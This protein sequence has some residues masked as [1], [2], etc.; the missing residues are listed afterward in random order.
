MTNQRPSFPDNANN[1]GVL[2]RSLS[3]F[4][5]II[6]VL[7]TLFLTLSIIMRRGIAVALALVFSVLLIIFIIY[8][9]G[10]GSTTNPE[11]ISER[12]R[13]ADAYNFLYD[14]IMPSIL[15]DFADRGFD[16]DAGFGASNTGTI[17]FNEPDRAAAAIQTFIENVVPRDYMQDRAE[18]FMEQIASYA[19]GRQ[20]EFSIDLQLDDRVR[21]LP[22]AVRSASAEISL[23]EI[24][25]NDIMAPI[26][27]STASELTFP[28]LGISFTPDEVLDAANRV[29]PADWIDQ[30]VF[31]AVDQLGPYLSGDADSFLINID[32]SERIPV[33]GDVLVETVQQKELASVLLFERVIDPAV[34]QAV[35]ELTLL[36]Y[37][38]PITGDEITE[39][40][41]QFAPTAWIE[42]E[43]E[44]VVVAV[45][46]YI[47]GESDSLAYSIDLKERKENGLDHLTELADAKLASVLSD[48]PKCKNDQQLVLAA[49]DVTELRLPRCSESGIDLRELRSAAV[50]LF[51]NEIRDRLLIHV[52]DTVG[53]TD[54]QFRTVLGLDATN[55]LEAVRNTIQQG[56][57]YTD[58]D[59]IS[60]WSKTGDPASFRRA[61]DTIR[62]G[63]IYS[64]VEF[65]RDYQ[66]FLDSQNI[67]ATIKGPSILFFNFD[68]STDL[69]TSRANFGRILGSIFLL[70]S[71]LLLLLLF[72]GLLGGRN[73][74]SR[75]MWVAGAVV[76]SASI[77]AVIF[78]PVYLNVGNTVS[79][80]IQAGIS[81]YLDEPLSS[82]PLT[83]QYTSFRSDFP[84]TAALVD[85]GEFVVRIKVFF[86]GMASGMLSHSLM[87][88]MSGLIVLS[89]ALVL[90]IYSRPGIEP[91]ETWTT[92]TGSIKERIGD[93]RRDQT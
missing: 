38:V 59:L 90:E 80:E 69:N 1:D 87:W 64:N 92:F 88:L 25:S 2:R 7:R 15:N 74:R 13:E 62:S 26:I 9:Q 27:E 24:I 56:L 33:L 70:G 20:N 53:Y 18:T 19:F 30:Q 50:T 14:R 61:L 43:A 54:S 34:K 86:D 91:P 5:S 17:R 23:G 12:L 32:Y 68:W 84:R 58:D 55:S 6:S 72:I 81:T 35:A 3:V 37:N 16:I 22:V 39:A 52:P 89:I 77:C 73:W 48:I 21:A 57:V 42:S 47:T 83:G 45:V 4:V 28:T 8:M 85:S 82:D 46:R 31:T 63:E 49:Q 51:H 93:R 11:F 44:N 60:D 79:N 29:M 71:P 41:R 67:P 40:V 10:I 65:E 78:G 66:N 76:I 75:L 36:S